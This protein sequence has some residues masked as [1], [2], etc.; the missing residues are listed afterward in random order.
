MAQEQKVAR[1][2]EVARKRRECQHPSHA[3]QSQS[4]SQLE[5]GGQNDDA[6]DDD[7]LLI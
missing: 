7:D 1:E 2:S 5:A 3:P 4:Q 6:E